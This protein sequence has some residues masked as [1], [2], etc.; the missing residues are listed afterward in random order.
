M[1]K[2]G[3]YGSPMMTKILF[4][5][6]LTPALCF[7]QENPGPIKKTPDYWI[8]AGYAFYP[9]PSAEVHFGQASDN[10][11]T[12]GF[13]A[14][15]I[16]GK[17]L[18]SFLYAGAGASVFSFKILNNPCIPV[19]ADIRVIGVGKY[20]L[21]SFLDPGYGFY[22]DSYNDPLVDP[23]VTVRE[24]GGFFIAYGFG[25]IYKKIYLQAKYN[26]LRFSTGS[27]TTGKR[28]KA[29]GV[30]GITLGVRFR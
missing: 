30:G 14:E 6:L 11:F 7:S 24:R 3:L 23:A 13:T 29:Y 27:T 16:A 12:S 26:W 1:V 4:L 22:E 21:Y 17:Q 10:P 9:G 20:K 5:I 19:F 8:D 2:I 28:S 25:V 15:F 18:N